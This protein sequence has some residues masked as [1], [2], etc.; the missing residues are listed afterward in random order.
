MNL[1]RLKVF[2]LAKMAFSAVQLV[3]CGTPGSGLGTSGL[4]DQLWLQ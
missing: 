3:W 1:I 4:S 2:P